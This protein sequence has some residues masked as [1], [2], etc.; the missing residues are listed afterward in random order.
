MDISMWF[1]HCLWA[2]MLGFPMLSKHL[3]NYC[4]A[5]STVKHNKCLVIFQ[6]RIAS[7]ISGSTRESYMS[8]RNKRMRHIAQAARVRTSVVRLVGAN[9]GFAIVVL[10]TRAQQW[11]RGFYQARFEL[12]RCS[13]ELVCNYASHAFSW[14]V[15]HNSAEMFVEACSCVE[16][17]S[18]LCC[19]RYLWRSTGLACNLCWRHFI[20]WQCV[21]D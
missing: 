6:T 15:R 8:R 1:T 10:D 18:R 2:H 7:I 9:H 20:S 14:Q 12:V 3:Q 11:L 21:Y 5:L 17:V 16:Q 13:V 19:H 4:N